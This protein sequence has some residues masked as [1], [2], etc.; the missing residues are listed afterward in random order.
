MK[1]IKKIL[2]MLLFILSSIFSTYTYAAD[3][4]LD[5]LKA[6]WIDPSELEWDST[7]PEWTEDLNSAPEN[8]SNQAYTNEAMFADH[9]VIPDSTGTT[10]ATTTNTEENFSVDY[11][12][13]TT[14]DAASNNSASNIEVTKLPQ[15]WPTETILLILSL[16]LTWAI[17]AYRKKLS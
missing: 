15:T 2:V 10:T 13:E 9:I 6:F 3:S 14:Q 8:P 7:L 11:W 4:D 5:F 12:N 16:M 17:Y 1:N